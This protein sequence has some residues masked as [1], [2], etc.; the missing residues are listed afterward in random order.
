MNTVIPD[1]PLELRIEQLDS[2]GRGVVSHDDLQIVCDG[3]LPDEVVRMR[4][5]KQRRRL[6]V[7]QDFTIIQASEARISPL[8]RYFGECGGCQL[9]HA[10]YDAQLAYKES[11]L[12]QSLARY[13]DVR[14]QQWLPALSDSPFHYRRRVRLGVRMLDDSGIVIGFHRKRRSY[15]LDISACPVLDPRLH[16]L[17]EPLHQLVPQLSVRHRLPQIEMTCGEQEVAVVFRHLLP[18]SANDR[19]LLQHF[20]EFQDVLVFT[21]AAG[22]ESMQALSEDQ[23]TSL[24][25]SLPRHQIRLTCSATDFIQANARINQMLIDAV[26]TELDLQEWDE[27]LDLFCGIG[28]FSLPM[29][30]Y[31]KSVIG[32]DGHPALVQRAR[33]NAEHN[34]LANARFQQADL[35]QW[36]ADM[37]YNKLLID[38]PREGAIDVLKR[39][40]ETGADTIVYV[41]CM[42]KTLARDARYL[43]HHRGYTMTK[44]GVVDMFPQTR[45]VEA[46]AVFRR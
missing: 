2:Q 14:P 9:Q 23:V 21:Q 11:F 13:G 25:Y 1:T 16:M 17:L 10:R 22:P 19:S 41:S 38:P 31:T 29:A 3:A 43:V 26:M 18:L 42:P 39:L 4:Q 6:M 5:F 40:P 37:N 32:I 24:Q 8:C 30:R 12:Q 28:N 15:L 7:A 27:V 36:S 33:S 45:H 46:M 20:A 44:A 35:G 34:G